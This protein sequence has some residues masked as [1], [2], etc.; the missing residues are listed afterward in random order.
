MSSSTYF[1]KL[2]D[3]ALFNWKG[4]FPDAIFELPTDRFNFIYN[5]AVECSTDLMNEDPKTPLSLR[6]QTLKFL[7]LNMCH[8]IC[9]DP[10]KLKVLVD[11][12]YNEIVIDQL[13]IPQNL[14]EELFDLYICCPKHYNFVGIAPTKFISVMYKLK[15]NSQLYSRLTRLSRNRRLQAIFGQPTKLYDL[16]SMIRTYLPDCN[17]MTTFELR[18]YIKFNALKLKNRHNL[19]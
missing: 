19:I 15:E 10:L 5:R 11:Y 14:K 16:A 18:R 6:S 7:H 13:E 4:G 12:T 8:K 9:Y 2:T 3:L 1:N 17:H